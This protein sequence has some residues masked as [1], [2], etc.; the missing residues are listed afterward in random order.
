MRT[1]EL[2]GRF[3][4]VPGAR[5]FLRG[6]WSRQKHLVVCALRLLR[7]IPVW[8][9][10]CLDLWFPPLPPPLR[11]GAVSFLLPGTGE[12]RTRVWL[13]LR[14][15]LGCRHACGGAPC[16]PVYT[17]LRARMPQWRLIGVCL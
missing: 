10:V 2:G 1:L 6:A 13:G 12:M 17:P 15:V 8:G 16:P 3:C 4:V 5:M 11:L 7:L 9:E 14:W